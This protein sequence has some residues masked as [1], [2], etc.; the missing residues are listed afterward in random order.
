MPYWIQLCKHLSTFNRTAKFSENIK[1]DILDKIKGILAFNS[2]I[3]C[4]LLDVIKSI[5]ISILETYLR[6]PSK[7]A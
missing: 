6:P 3:N 5:V 4:N 2:P 1:V 7:F